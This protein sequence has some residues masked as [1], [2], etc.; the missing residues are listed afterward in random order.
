MTLIGIMELDATSNW[1]PR[2][3]YQV[4]QNWIMPTNNCYTVRVT[5]RLE[6]KY[7]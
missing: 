2:Y 5:Q 7:L 3:A 1:M 6:D 4:D